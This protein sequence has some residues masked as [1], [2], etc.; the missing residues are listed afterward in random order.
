MTGKKQ[1]AIAVASGLA[2]IFG[3]GLAAP[4]AA[5]T[6]AIR[7]GRL[8]TDAALP[9]RGPATVIVTDGRITAINDA[10][11]PIPAGAT[12]VDATTK[13]VLP[14]LMDAHVHLGGDADDAWYLAFT[15]KRT[16]AY[17]VAVGLHNALV[18]ARAG[19]TTVRELGAGVRSGVAVRDA[20]NDGLA[21]G[22]RI[23]TAG[24]ALSIIG[25]HGDNTYGINPDIADAIDHD[26]PPINLCTGADGCAAATRAVIKTGVDVI[27]I[28]ATGGVL[29]LGNAGL[30]QHFSDAEM[31]V[32]AETAHRLGLKVAA[33]AHGARGIEA[34]ANAGIDSIEHGTY[35]DDAS[36]KAMKTHGT[37]MVATLM[38]I[39]GLKERL[40]KN[41]YTPKV[42]A[43]ARSV[44]GLQG[45]QLAA[46]YKAG[47]PIALGTDAGV[48][49]HG[50]NGEELGLMVRLGGMTPRDALVA[51]TS[52][53]AKLLGIDA[54]T[55]TLAPGKS[56]DLIA[57]DGDPLQDPA[58][59]LKVSYVMVRGKTIPMQ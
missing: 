48:F 17:S 16:E 51:A 12:I 3:I 24:P 43:K 57:V 34:A 40:G 10:N 14:G 18:T 50:R 37:Y 13:T 55:G 26:H 31:R 46:A 32:I 56:A 8:I 53:A 52:G 33:H 36:I 20:I 59:V 1:L 5:E 38:A 44:V 35:A 41:F 11:A 7:A 27:K 54:E 30:E 58:A 47:V 25:G 22:P 9:A 42:E 49:A 28:T 23:L 2:T 21:P 4:A 39:E 45:R 15:P 29:S 19:F 6:I